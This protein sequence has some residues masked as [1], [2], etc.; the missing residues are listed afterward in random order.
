MTLAVNFA[1]N[2]GTKPEDMFWPGAAA[3]RLADALESAGREVRIMAVAPTLI[4]HVYVMVRMIAK[5]YGEVL[6]LD[7]IAGATAFPGAFRSAG[8]IAIATACA[9]VGK[10][11]PM[12][13]GTPLDLDDFPDSEIDGQAPAVIQVPQLRILAAAERFLA[14]VQSDMGG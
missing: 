1:T 11:V 2:A 12:G 7:R 5:D 9:R 10:R 4:S 8:F 3:I 13:L 6:D 14:S